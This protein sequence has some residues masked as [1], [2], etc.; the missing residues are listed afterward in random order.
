M[1]IFISSTFKD[2]RPERQ[3][4]IDVLRQ[5]E[6]LPWGMELF[7]SSPSRPIDEAL[8]EVQLSDAV[9]LIIGF[10]AGSLIP[11]SPALTY[12]AAEFHRAR[13]LDIPVFVFIQ[14]QAGQWINKEPD[15]PLKNALDEFKK[16]VDGANL[17]PSYFDNPD[18]LKTEILL[19]ME[20]WN[21]QGRPGA[22]LVFTSPK[23]FFAPFHATK[24]PR[25]FDFEQTLRGR[26]A[27]LEGLNNFLAAE[28]S[29]I[30]VL[31]GRGG[32]GKSKLIHDWTR[33]IA[34]TTVLYVRDNAVWHGE[35]A[36]EI[37]VGNIIIVADDA[38]RLTFLDELLMLVRALRQ[39][40]NIKILLG[41]RP[42]GTGQIDAS[43]STRFDTSQIIRF[44]PLQQ[45]ARQSVLELA[46]EV[47]GPTHGQY[48]PGLAS[49]SADTPLVTVV[50]GRL[51][52]RG[53]IAPALLA[54]QDDFRH[55]VFDRFSAEYER[56]LAAGPVDWRNLLNL[57]AALGPLDPNA[58]KFLTPA[59]EVLHVRIDEIRSAVDRLE[60]SGLLLRG[61][62][63]VRIVPDLLSD[64]LLEGA[65]VTRSGESTTFA[66]LV[67]EMFR[68]TYLSNILRNLG[69]LD[70]R[71]THVNQD[72]RL[73]DR[74]WDE[75]RK[76]FRAADASGRRDLLKSLHEAAIFQPGPVS[77]LVRLAIE[78]EAAPTKVLETWTITQ[79][80]VLRELPDLL[81]PIA[82][83]MQYFDGAIRTLWTLQQIENRN[84]PTRPRDAWHSLEELAEYRRYKPASLNCRM[85]DLILEF[86]R[87]PGAFDGPHTPL[88]L[89]D[90]LLVKEG[91]FTEGDGLTVSFGGFPLNYN[92]VNPSRERALELLETTLHSDSPRVALRAI[93]SISH[94]LSGFLTMGGRQVSSEELAW[95]DAERDRVLTM[96][97]NRLRK[98]AIAALVIRE[99][100]SVLLEIRRRTAN[101]ALAE[102]IDT[103]LNAAPQS[104]HVLIF[105]G[106]CSGA[107]DHDGRFAN[108]EEAEQDRREMVTRSVATFRKKHTSAKQ[109]VDALARLVADAESAGVNLSG[110]CSDFIEQ[111][112]SDQSFLDAF[113]DYVLD[114]PKYV[115]GYMISIPLASLRTVDPAR[116]MKLGLEGASHKTT[117]I[118]LGTASGV[119]YCL[120]QTEPIAEDLA[121]LEALSRHKDW[122]VRDAALTAIG[123]L[124]AHKSF[125]RDAIALLIRMDIED[126][127][128]LAEE[129]CEQFMYRRI[130]FGA[131]AEADVQ[132]ILNKLVPV[133]EIDEY[134]TN[135]FLDRVGQA[136]PAALFHF[137]I[138]RLD[139]G[140]ALLAKDGEMKGYVPV[141]GGRFGAAFKS[142]S[143]D[144]GASA[145]LFEIRDR[146]VRQPR[147][148]YWF[149]ELFWDIGTVDATTLSVIDE[150]LHSG[151][152]EK[153]RA[154]IE[155]TSGAPSELALTRPYFAVH[156]LELC[157][158]IDH[159]LL[160][161]GSSV[162][163]GNA[164]TGSS[165]RIPGS[166]SPK[167]QGL[168]QRAATLRDQ[169]IAGSIAHRFFSKLHESASGGLERERLDD[170]Q[171]R[172]Q[173]QAWRD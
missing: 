49:V 50:G 159:T 14:T 105:E 104:D 41:T 121:I 115:L 72:V 44:A 167:Y 150:L 36:K 48:A 91:Q 155:L 58:D 5:A 29:I 24:A 127:A 143:A 83:H 145:F 112:N 168:E 60:Q 164:H 156:L 57:I 63:L 124:G 100:R 26:T 78:T 34:G 93:R 9:I 136:Y 64:F 27:E 101:A 80:N 134:H 16:A 111:L 73:L 42:S 125:E 113:V 116:Y 172:F 38:H 45:V 170:D 46:Q 97:E 3:A 153:M 157:E 32:I 75:I 53:D 92:V 140:A 40:Q 6:L 108:L 15:G 109:Q 154:A 61:G 144:A 98:P 130:D 173:N 52:A 66:D 35:A 102:R 149:R 89:A 62:R 43:L 158:Q 103:V 135:L 128:A 20:K 114:D 17:L 129:L 82:H 77:E 81:R 68:E 4:A 39:R 55:A 74:I 96:L 147:Q 67:F 19:A 2:L 25:L 131:L 95:Q 18:Q 33:D 118:A 8:R 169:F 162:L 138:E 69:E 56:V 71:M 21:A 47:L 65:C 94:V 133:S 137:L 163:I 99:I 54:N 11:E 141:P 90:K 117:N 70:W 12:T 23:E 142:L 123:R 86:A 148:G 51:I 146:F 152:S 84:R 79:S 132:A 31:P 160:E 171:L 13:E 139:R 88:D 28:E 76:T 87:L 30:G 161:L 22:R 85:G 10:K 151:E 37:P 165:Q 166:P 126:I 120:F 110:K 106:F 107:Y 7:V 122:T 119:R 1:R 59:A